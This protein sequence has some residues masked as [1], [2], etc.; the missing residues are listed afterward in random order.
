M[1][2]KEGPGT[3]ELCPTKLNWTNPVPKRVGKREKEEGGRGR[4]AG[5]TVFQ[6]RRPLSYSSQT[7][8][9]RSRN[10]IK[11]GLQWWW[12]RGSEVKPLEWLVFSLEWSAL[13]VDIFASMTNGWD[14]RGR[15]EWERTSLCSCRWLEVSPC[16]DL[17][18]TKA[19]H[20]WPCH[21]PARH[22]DAPSSP[23][24][25]VVTGPLQCPSSAC[26]PSQQ[27]IDLVN[28]LEGGRENP[29]LTPPPITKEKSG[30]KPKDS[31][32]Y[33]ISID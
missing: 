23:S 10:R 27:Q 14:Q 6:P 20:C 17:D 28:S 18:K 12:V 9:G 21:G 25:M 31:F 2:F 29:S 16:Q 24:S 13:L 11:C 8:S 7:L 30:W 32:L 1:F 3:E 33:L 26:P 4:P 22:G 5:T 15:H 19:S